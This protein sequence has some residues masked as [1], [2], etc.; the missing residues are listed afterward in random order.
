MLL[1]LALKILEIWIYLNGL[2]QSDL[3]KLA[4]AFITSQLDYFTL[5][6]QL[7]DDQYLYKTLMALY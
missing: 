2:S 4:S 3:E 7:L 5:N 1:F 6:Q